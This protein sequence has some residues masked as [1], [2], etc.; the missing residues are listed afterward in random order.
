MINIYAV[1][2]YIQATEVKLK[3][4]TVASTPHP[5]AQLKSSLEQRIRIRGAPQRGDDWAP[6][7]GLHG[8][9]TEYDI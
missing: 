8:R 7:R 4:A 2:R 6:A 9:P 5:F 3:H 1:P